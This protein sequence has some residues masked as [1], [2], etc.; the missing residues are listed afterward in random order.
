[1]AGR[2]RTIPEVSA[3]DRFGIL[4]ALGPEYIQRRRRVVRVQCTSCRRVSV[5]RVTDLIAGD[6]CKCLTRNRRR[7]AYLR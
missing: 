5:I 3:N 6:Q 2:P 7:G 4:R 1:M